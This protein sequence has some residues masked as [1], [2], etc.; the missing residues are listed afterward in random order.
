MTIKDSLVSLYNWYYTP[1]ENFKGDSPGFIVNPWKKWDQAK[2]FH[3]FGFD[4]NC[5][6]YVGQYSVYLD[7][8]DTVFKLYEDKREQG[9][10]GKDSA[11][12]KFD[13]LETKNI[14]YLNRRLKK[15]CQRLL[16]YGMPDTTILYSKDVDLWC[17][18]IKA[19]LGENRIKDRPDRQWLLA[20]INEAEHSKP[21]PKSRSR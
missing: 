20:K 10:I 15:I 16:D 6:L 13:F 3:I 2:F 19:I 12:V 14:V 4:G 18:P 9:Y 5:N 11:Y 17:P 7:H 8:L 21:P 1:G